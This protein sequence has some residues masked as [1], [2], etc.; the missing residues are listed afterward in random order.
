[1][2]GGPEEI[3]REYSLLFNN[4]ESLWDD[5]IAPETSST[6]LS[7]RVT[8][9]INRT[10][11][12]AW[13][14]TNIPS[15]EVADLSA[16]GCMEIRISTGRDF[17]ER[18]FKAHVG[19]VLASVRLVKSSQLAGRFRASQMQAVTQTFIPAHI[20]SPAQSAP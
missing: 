20:T 7:R 14:L 11:L 8:H 2:S 1:M 9:V 15:V 5:P 16:S 13:A 12:L 6:L 18:A 19:E 10:S 4:N 17:N 3:T